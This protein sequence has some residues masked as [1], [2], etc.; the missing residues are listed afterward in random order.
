SPQRR[1]NLNTASQNR[2][3]D[4]DT[5]AI[6]PV[7]SYVR[8]GAVWAT[9]CSDAI[10]LAD[11]R[12]ALRSMR[13]SP[14][15]AAVAV[16]TLALGIGLTAAIFSAVDAILLRPLDLPAPDRLIHVREKDTVIGYTGSVS[17]PNFRDWK[18]Q[19]SS[20][21]HLSMYGFV[22]RNLQYVAEPVRL[23]GV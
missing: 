14:G 12:F 15:F 17:V 8:R 11:L 18:A 4:A 2:T 7:N 19:S 16:T 23:R 6:R 10:M 20:F 1:R 21:E 22:S 9:T 3:A 5:G 13:M